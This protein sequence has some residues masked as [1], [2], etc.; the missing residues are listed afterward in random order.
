MQIIEL[1]KQNLE[2]KYIHQLL[3]QKICLIGVFSKLCIHCKSMKQEWNFLKKKLKN[4]KCNGLLLEIDSQ[5]LNY[6]DYSSLNKSINGFPS[7]MIFKNGKL[8]KEYNGNRKQTDMFK[9]FKPY[10]VLINGKTY[11]N[12]SLKNRITLRHKRRIKDTR[13]IK[14]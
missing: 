12:K 11:K 4:K 10:L 1:D 2:K 5:Q 14:N 8:V 7:I 6:I 9:F 3:K 13:R